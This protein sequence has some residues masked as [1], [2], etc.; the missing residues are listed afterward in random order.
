MENNY[1]ETKIA[2]YK[3][4]VNELE[5]KLKKAEAV[6]DM[7]KVFLDLEPLQKFLDGLES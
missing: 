3:R 4:R 5:D 7:E 1:N 2:Y 6:E